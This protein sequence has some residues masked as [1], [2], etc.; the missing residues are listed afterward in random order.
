MVHACYFFFNFPIAEIVSVCIA[1]ALS[2]R[3]Q[4]FTFQIQLL[5][6][7][8]SLV[9][10]DTGFMPLLEFFIIK[11]VFQWFSERRGSDRYINFTANHKTLGCK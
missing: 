8:E 1:S 6:I 9:L 7:W 11:N 3:N 10:F 5:W 4:C 2:F